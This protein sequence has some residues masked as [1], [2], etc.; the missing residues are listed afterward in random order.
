MHNLFKKGQNTRFFLKGYPR[1][2][3]R[4]IIEL[5]HEIGQKSKVGESFRVFNCR[6]SRGVI[7]H[8]IKASRVFPHPFCFV[9]HHNTFNTPLPH[10]IPSG[11]PHASMCVVKQGCQD[12][13]F[14]KHPRKYHNLKIYS[15]FSLIIVRTGLTR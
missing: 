11:Q 15:M 10:P 13:N 7:F 3:K 4:S 14:R 6:I 1:A 5:E 8:L 2:S 12:Q 9:T